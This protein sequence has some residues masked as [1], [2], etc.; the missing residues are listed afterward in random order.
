MSWTNPGPPPYYGPPPSGPPPRQTQFPQ[1]PPVPAPP[2]NRGHH[3]DLPT[4]RHVP[5]IPRGDRR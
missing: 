2:L 4:F 5:I 3:V 1:K